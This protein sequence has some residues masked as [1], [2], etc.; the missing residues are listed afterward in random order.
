M[1]YDYKAKQ[2]N[3][4]Q[5]NDYMLAKTLSMFEYENLPETIP[6]RELEKLLQRRGYVFI[7]KAP[8]GELYAFTG[9]L[10]GET[11]VYGNA[12][13]I[14][15][16]NAALKYNATL[17][18]KKDG[19]LF[20]NDDM[21]AGLLAF[22]EKQ[23]TLLV[24]NE[25]NMVVWGYNS[26]TQKLI[27]APDDKSKESA[28]LYMKKI[29][30]G[31][32]TIIGENAL[33]DGVKV[34]PAN[35][36]SGNGISQMI[37]YHQYIKSCLFNEVGIPSNFNMKKER[38]I[39]SEIA[40]ADDSL[41][42]L[43]YNMM[44]NRISAVNS[45]NEMFGTDIKVGFGSVWALKNK[46]L[47][48]GIVNNNDDLPNETMPNNNSDDRNEGGGSASDT[49]PVN[50]QDNEDDNNQAVDSESNNGDELNNG[51]SENEQKQRQSNNQDS[52]NNSRNGS[53]SKETIDELQA[54]ID[55]PDSSDGDKQAA[56]EL[57][58]ELLNKEID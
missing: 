14:I 23:N 43:V 17:D 1:P 18:L 26:R 11:D 39:T 50:N 57:L 16:A 3:V 38:L 27:S 19:V 48:D 12:T 10:G 29:V 13:Q 30:D 7:T 55:S 25:I 8:D 46:K 6:A 4:N 42:P 53:E 40:Q 9:G 31:E 58:T 54:V 47:V 24:E 41:F 44:E 28:E 20:Y 35:N 21:A 37:E 33:F 52:D 45:I 32:L 5:L 36:S 51:E 56:S 34:Q 2:K 22:Y 15:I 49:G